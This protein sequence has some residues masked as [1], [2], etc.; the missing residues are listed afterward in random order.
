M[1]RALELIATTM[2]PLRGVF[3]SAGALDDGAL[4]QQT[5]DRFAHRAR[6]K[7]DGA[8]PP[9]RADAR[10]SRSTTSS[11]TR[12]SRRC[13][14][15][16]ARPTTPPPT[17]S[18]TPLAH[19]RA[20][21]GQPGL[22]INWGAWSEVGAAAE[23]GVDKRGG[24]AGRRRHHRPPTAWPCSIALMA[25]RDAAGRRDAGAVAR[26]PRSGYG[27]AGPPPY[28]AEL[29]HVAATARP[30]TP[31]AG[32]AEPTSAGS[33]TTPPAHRRGGHRCSSFVREQSAHVLGARRPARSATALPLSELGLDSLMAVE[34]RNLLGAALGSGRPLPAT[35]VFDYPTVDAIAGYLADEVLG[36]RR[37]RARPTERRRRPRR[38]RRRP[39]ARC[40]S[41]LLDDLDDLS[42]DEIDRQ[43][44]REE[45]PTV[46][47]LFERLERSLSPKRLALLA[48]ELQERLDAA[49]ARP[50]PSRSPSS[51]WR[52]RLPGADDPEAY[53][54]LLVDGVDAI[55]EI[56]A[57]RWDVDAY[58]D[59]DPDAPGKIA[60]R[61]GGFLD[62]IDRFEPQF[63]GISPREAQS[64]DPQQRLLLEV[65]WEALEHAGIAPDSLQG[66]ATGVYVG[67]CNGDY[68]Q[69]LHGRRR[70]RTST[71][72]CR[73]ATPAASPPA[74]CP[75]CSA[76]RA[77]RSP[78]TPRARRRWSPCTSPCRALRDGA[79][80]VGAGRRRQR[81]PVP[82]DDD[83]ALAGQDDGG[84]RA[85]QGV[86]RPRR[87]L[88]ARRGLRAGG[89]QA[90]ERRRGRRRHGAGRH[91]RA[92]PS[93]R[94]GAATG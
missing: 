77:R 36:A 45:R 58:Y 34:L 18:S 53:W 14:A 87:R 81:H 82:E 79:C 15:R 35:L 1:A 71:C 24:R 7:V 59:P 63:F 29:A 61:W 85:V 44:A 86:R 25:R 73:P 41:S 49:D 62:G 92:R 51:A 89:A 93:T 28:F 9:R 47:E 33:W 84:R 5:W 69:L 75:T 43:L 46:T 11:C 20:A 90:A 67:I 12:R 52:C 94:T 55:R 19:R 4:G 6:A 13:S 65:A 83:D 3:H 78:S 70:P 54:Q 26:A 88:R 56:P 50:A 91:P 8:A 38:R 57:S 80:R 2:P 48:L 17:P 72:T 27:A 74:A 22:S 37:R 10:R 23:R 60:T 31:A 39:T 40:V 66:S 16:P 64:M 68:G 21:C 30:P 76:C 42:D 32:A